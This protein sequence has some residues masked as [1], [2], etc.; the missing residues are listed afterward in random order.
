MAELN[1]ERM[2]GA[3]VTVALGVVLIPVVY[4]LVTTANITDSTIALIVSLIP[5]LFSLAI[6]VGIL[7]PMF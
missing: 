2:I 1:F 5:L 4:N 7:K 3:L 6:V